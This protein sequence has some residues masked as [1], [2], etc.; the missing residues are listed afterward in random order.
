MRK[1]L[2][3]KELKVIFQTTIIFFTSFLLYYCLY[4]NSNLSVTAQSNTD[5]KLINN[6]F[7]P[8][9]WVAEAKEI[10]VNNKIVYI[11][12]DGIGSSP[13]IIDASNPS[14]PKIID[15]RFYDGIYNPMSVDENY[16]II[17]FDLTAGI[18]PDGA[19]A[20]IMLAYNKINATNF[21]DNVIRSQ[22]RIQ[23]I[24]YDGRFLFIFETEYISEFS[25]FKGIIE[26]YYM[27][28]P[29]NPLLI[30]SEIIYDLFP[31]N[32]DDRGFATFDLYLNGNYLFAATNYYDRIDNQTKSHFVIL[33][34]YYPGIPNEI[35][36]YS[37]LPI[38]NLF[39]K[40]DRIIARNYNNTISIYNC[41]DLTEISLL[42]NYELYNSKS[43]F[44]EDNSAYVITD[45]YF[46]ILNITD[47]SNITEQGSFEGNR[48]GVV[49]V[50]NDLAYISVSEKYDYQP[51][52]L[53]I[54]DIN[55][56]DN[57]SF[58]Y[59]YQKFLDN[60]FV[61]IIFVIIIVALSFLI[62]GIFLVAVIFKGIRKIKKK[63]E[64]N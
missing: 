50:E 7:S 30:S 32:E 8:N 13:T 62:S 15:L 51:P 27:I 20:K 38:E 5:S 34:Y 57:I 6:D 52:F 23:K 33:D 47:L 3:E 35:V 43:L 49:T 39:F 37:N 54:M 64:N 63:K 4:E 48:F 40:D 18:Q 31:I 19:E 58:V 61:F 16:T 42:Y 10:Y 22:K 45:E 2:R 17:S 14:K 29:E 56:I 25:N 26:C 1:I 24:L 41:T 36:E 11:N 9:F 21:I 46:K 59:S 53:Y 28:D 55:D 12:F 44:V 60:A